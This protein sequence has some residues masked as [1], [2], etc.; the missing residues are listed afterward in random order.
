MVVDTSALVAILKAE[1]EV[2]AFLA[3]LAA[4]AVCRLSAANF[5]EAGPVASRDPTGA[6]PAAREGRAR[7]FTLRS[8]PVSER[9]ARVALD[10]FRRYGRGTGH[11]AGRNDG[12]GFA[13]APAADTGEPLRGKGDDVPRTDR[14]PA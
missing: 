12:D 5:V 3:K 2:V 1:P 6:H 4:A 7:A 11:P 13:D 10:A 14:G 9:Q 8:E